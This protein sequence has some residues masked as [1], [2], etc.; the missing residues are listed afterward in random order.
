MSKWCLKKFKIFG[1]IILVCS[2]F[3]FSISN[4]YADTKQPIQ[5]NISYFH[6]P[7]YLIEGEVPGGFIIDIEREIFEHA[8]Y[9]LNFVA[10]SY[11]RAIR[12]AAKGKYDFT[13]AMI[14]MAV[15]GFIYPD[16]EV[17]V[18]EQMFVVKKGN[19][20]RYDG[21]NSLKGNT[22]GNIAFYDYSSISKEYNNYLLSTE[23]D[24]T[25]VSGEDA[26]LR[27]LKMISKGRVDT[28]S[29]SRYIL[30][31]IMFQ[32]KIASDFDFAGKLSKVLLTKLGFP[33]D[34][35]QSKKLIKIFDE[36]MT[37]IR[38]DGTLEKIMKKYNLSTWSS[39][40]KNPL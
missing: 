26:T 11:A 17:A 27:M 2:V 31:Y 28:F 32:N 3:P 33:Q 22:I 29:E 8:G 1:Y 36:G 5:L 12:E 30:E 9:K 25:M 34:A 40:F 24:V 38:K 10:F 14:P 23:A 21:I 18:S 6:Y 39:L 13:A 19:P 15:P 37:R 16:H 4:A 7:P 35:S 20:W